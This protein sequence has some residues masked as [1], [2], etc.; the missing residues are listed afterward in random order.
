[1]GYD[2]IC[3]CRNAPLYILFIH[4]PRL[5]L[6][7]FLDL[8]LTLDPVEEPLAMDARV[9]NCSACAL[10]SAAVSGEEILHV[11]EGDDDNDDNDDYR[12]KFEHGWQCSSDDYN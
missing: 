2:R 3:G 1:M 6:V 12:N 9:H 5:D 7:L 8:A 10:C 4:A 11:D